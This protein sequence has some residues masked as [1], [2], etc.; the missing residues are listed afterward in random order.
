MGEIM[1]LGPQNISLQRLVE[2]TSRPYE[3][4]AQAAGAELLVVF[5]AHLPALCSERGAMVTQLLTKIL[6]RLEFFRGGSWR[7]AVSSAGDGASGSDSGAKC[8]LVRIAVSNSLSAVPGLESQSSLRNEERPCGSDERLQALENCRALARVLG[9]DVHVFDDHGRVVRIEATIL[10]DVVSSGGQPRAFPDFAESEPSIRPSADNEASRGVVA[11]Q[12][13]EHPDCL[14]AETP[15]FAGLR[16]LVVDDNEFNLEVFESILAMAGIQVTTA[17][18]GPA[19]LATLERD[20]GLDVVLMD[21]QMPEMDGCETARRIRENPKLY[22]IPILALTAN[23]APDA[24]EQCL[25]A[26]MNDFLTKPL[27]TAAMF[28]ALTRWTRKRP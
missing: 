18:S 20:P 10:L 16:T 6:S 7:L 9:G 15:S 21:M 3:S 27:D 4:L 17:T 5:G 13:G 1:K 14:S 19:A 11:D 8:V 26:G 2:D 24:R 25:A 12:G 22:G 28:K 23:N